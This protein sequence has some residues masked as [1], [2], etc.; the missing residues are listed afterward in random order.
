M[1]MPPGVYLPEILSFLT[2]QEVVVVLANLGAYKC[3]EIPGMWALEPL[4]P[5]LAVTRHRL[6]E[7]T[8]EKTEITDAP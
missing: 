5:H 7:H 3:S 4:L 6:E 2:E 1:L 8:N